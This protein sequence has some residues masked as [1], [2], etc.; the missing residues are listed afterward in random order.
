MHLSPRDIFLTAIKVVGVIILLKA[1]H[2]FIV[3]IPMITVNSF[4]TRWEVWQVLLSFISP[5]VLLLMGIYLLKQAEWLTERLWG[6]KQEQSEPETTPP[7]VLFHLA[8]KV[9]GLV[10]IVMALPVAFRVLGNALYINSVS[11][12]ISTVYQTEFIYREVLATLVNLLLGFY[13]LCSGR[14]FARLA[15]PEREE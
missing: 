13:L 3:L 6:A 4:T 1:L 10:L 7:Q 2:Q 5:L 8:L 14:F 12:A 11:G 15:Y 9:L